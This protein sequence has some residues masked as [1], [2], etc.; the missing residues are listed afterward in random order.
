MDLGIWGRN[1]ANEDRKLLRY[2]GLLR[3]SAAATAVI[4]QVA[5]ESS[6]FIIIVH[7]LLS[8]SLVARH[9]SCWERS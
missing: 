5:E 2:D 3:I 9:G 4:F 6:R 7:E 1:P 8:Q